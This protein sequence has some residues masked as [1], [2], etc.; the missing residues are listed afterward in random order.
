LTSYV[1]LEDLVFTWLFLKDTVISELE[2]LST[3]ILVFYIFSVNFMFI[4]SIPWNDCLFFHYTIGV[5]F[6]FRLLT[7]CLSHRL[8]FPQFNLYI[9]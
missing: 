6:M 8:Y 7:F 4:Y 5:L 1:S 9:K 2:H 3:N